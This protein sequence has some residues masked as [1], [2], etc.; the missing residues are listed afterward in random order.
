[1]TTTLIFMFN[2]IICITA[3]YIARK[4]GKNEAYLELLKLYKEAIEENGKLKALLDFYKRLI[5]KDK[6]G[7]EHDKSNA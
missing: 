4:V 6:K 7:N 5:L 1:M 2:L 3:L